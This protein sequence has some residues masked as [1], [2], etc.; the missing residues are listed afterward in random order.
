MKP[1]TIKVTPKTHHAGRFGIKLEIRG[2]GKGSVQEKGAPIPASEESLPHFDITGEFVVEADM[3]K[4]VGDPPSKVGHVVETS[5]LGLLLCYIDG[6]RVVS[7]LHHS[8][9]QNDF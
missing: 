3:V 9:S 2:R 6:R 8:C 4:A 1:S 7:P 5:R